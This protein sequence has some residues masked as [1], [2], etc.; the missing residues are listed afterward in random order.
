MGNDRAQRL[1]VGAVWLLV[2]ASLLFAPSATEGQVRITGRTVDHQDETPVDAVAVT[3]LDGEEE[4]VATRFSDEDGR[5]SFVV[6]G[7]PTLQF[8]ARRIGYRA[9][10]T[11]ELDLANLSDFRAL[12]LEIRLAPD[13][14]PVA[15]LEVVTGQRR[16]DSPVLEGYYHRK[17]VGLGDYITREEIEERDPGQ[18]TDLLRSVPGVRLTSSGRGH[19]GV[20]TTTRGNNSFTGVCPAQIYVDD[21]HINRSDGRTFRIDDVVE[22]E[23]V[24]G[25]E[26]YRGLSTVPAQFLSLKADCGVIVIWTRRSRG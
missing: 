2:P 25:I 8:R 17:E 18:V 13:G 5:F 23:D 19:R 15:P 6:E 11:P 3:V 12:T 14:V 24:E 20:V 16:H 4:E 22:P 21:F 7:T 9:V 10:N 1:A 26:V